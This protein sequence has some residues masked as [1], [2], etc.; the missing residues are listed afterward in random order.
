MEPLSRNVIIDL[1]P[2]YIAGEASEETRRLVEEYAARDPRIA[3]LL[4]SEARRAAPLPSGIAAP[5][6]L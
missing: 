2:A 4:R 5:G 1:L 6:D 3:E